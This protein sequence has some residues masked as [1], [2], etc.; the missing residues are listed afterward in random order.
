MRLNTPNARTGPS[1]RSLQRSVKL[2]SPATIN[3]V[4]PG[5]NQRHRLSHQC[6]TSTAGVQPYY[7]ESEDP[8][9]AI[10]IAST[11]DRCT[12]DPEELAGAERS[13]AAQQAAG[14][15]PPYDLIETKVIDLSN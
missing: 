8:D 13:I 2:A 12:V 9:A 6:P 3:G 15:P 7:S 4:F 10:N 1:I 11:S 5:Q 14:L